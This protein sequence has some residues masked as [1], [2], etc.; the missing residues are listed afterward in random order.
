ML[1]EG[2]AVGDAVAMGTLLGAVVG[3]FDGLTVD[4]CEGFLEGVAVTGFPVGGGV[5]AK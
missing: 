5:G 2:T 1:T 3:I 4:G